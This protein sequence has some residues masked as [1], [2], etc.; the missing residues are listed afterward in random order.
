M[1]FLRLKTAQYV[2][3][4]NIVNLLFKIL[5]KK[6]MFT[7][8]VNRVISEAITLQYTNIWK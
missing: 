8:R 6:M 4:I 7:V 3:C 2:Y 5:K 1:H